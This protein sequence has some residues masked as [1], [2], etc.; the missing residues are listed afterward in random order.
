MAKKK[1]WISYLPGADKE[2]NLKAFGGQLDKYG[3]TVSA[4]FWEDDLKKLAWVN[5]REILEDA[6]QSDIWLVAG[7]KEQFE[8]ESIRYGLSVLRLSIVPRRK[9]DIPVFILALGFR[10]EPEDLPLA[11]RDAT[12]FTDG[13]P[14][15]AAKLVARAHKKQAGAEYPY[16]FFV[17]AHEYFG[18]WFEIGP[19]TGSWNGAMFGVS[20]G[21]ITHHAVGPGGFPP[22]KSVVE[23]SLRGIKAE[24]GGVEYTAWAVQNKIGEDESYYVKVVGSPGKVIFGEHPGEKDAEVFVYDLF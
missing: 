17:H 9:S 5:H 19:S 4:G 22:E 12:I 3:F 2:A 7:E 11:F 13:D 8:R 14:G 1:L 16:R 6:S 20:E 21:E 10:L 24:L 15:W 23:Y 18:Q